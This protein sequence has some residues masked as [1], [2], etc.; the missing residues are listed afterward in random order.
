MNILNLLVK[1]GLNT[2]DVRFDASFT[3]I[4]SFFDLCKN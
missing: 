3:L 2:V 1:V 4:D